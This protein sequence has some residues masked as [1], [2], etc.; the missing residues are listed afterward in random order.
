MDCIVQNLQTHLNL[1][2]QLIHIQLVVVLRSKRKGRK[3]LVSEFCLAV[4]HLFKLVY[5]SRQ[6]TLSASPDFTTQTKNL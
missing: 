1:K 2:L 6:L 5:C 3:D 4:H